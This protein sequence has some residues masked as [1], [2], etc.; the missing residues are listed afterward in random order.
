MFD[1]PLFP[2]RHGAFA[3][4]WHIGKGIQTSRAKLVIQPDIKMKYAKQLAGLA[5]RG[6]HLIRLDQ[7]QTARQ[8][9]RSRHHV[10]R[11]LGTPRTPLARGRRQAWK[12]RICALCETNRA[13]ARARA[14]IRP[15][16]EPIP[17]LFQV[18][19]NSRI[20]FPILGSSRAL[21]RL[22]TV[23]DSFDTK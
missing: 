14:A 22:K 15:P 11:L 7:Y 17:L 5:A 6:P 13:D 19:P 10:I 3:A 8:F 9:I 4:T 20:S 16:R 21:A 1:A 12:P 23:S 18:V 2:G